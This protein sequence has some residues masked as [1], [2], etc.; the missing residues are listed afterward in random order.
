MSDEVEKVEENET[1]KQK[2]AKKVAPAVTVS[3]PVPA[4]TIDELYVQNPGERYMYAAQGTPKEVLAEEGLEVVMRHGQPMISRGRV[5]CRC[6]NGIQATKMS[7]EYQESHRAIAEVR[8]IK[9]T[10]KKS[11][12]AEA[13]EIEIPEHAD[14]DDRCFS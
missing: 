12:V 11:K 5:V 6:V 13:S 8:D 2:V 1:E 7:R 10:D 4:K 14:P 3:S 9:T